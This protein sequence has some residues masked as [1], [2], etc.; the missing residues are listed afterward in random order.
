MF[1]DS[2]E[3]DT[4]S[5]ALN[6]ASVALFL[7]KTSHLPPAALSVLTLGYPSCIREPLT[8]K[9]RIDWPVWSLCTLQ[10]PPVMSAASYVCSVIYWKSPRFI[11]NKSA[12]QV[13]GPCVTTPKVLVD[14]GQ[15]WC[16]VFCNNN[17]L[18]KEHSHISK[19]CV[20]AGAWCVWQVRA[21]DR[22]ARDRR[23]CIEIHRR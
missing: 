22:G 2:L 10:I 17:N 20:T 9:A 3:S 8:P 7:K 18:Q 14:P 12:G 6:Q 1:S 21:G 11:K 23:S 5:P 16:C 15:C 4:P 13:R 19:C